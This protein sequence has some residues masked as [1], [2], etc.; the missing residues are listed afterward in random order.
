L[1]FDEIG[2][3]LGF[4]PLQWIICLLGCGVSQDVSD[5][6]WDLLFLKGHKVI[7][8]FFLAIMHSLKSELLKMLDFDQAMAF[9]E[10]R[11]RHLIDI[12]TLI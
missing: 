1:H 2:I 4:L 10:E 9:I 12:D 3:D 8:Q 11:P 7:F 5:R 6:I